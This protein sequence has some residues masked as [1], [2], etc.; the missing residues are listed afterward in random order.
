MPALLTPQEVSHSCIWWHEVTL[1][2]GPD[3]CNGRLDIWAC[4][5]LFY[6]VDLGAGLR[7]SSS[8]YTCGQHFRYHWVIDEAMGNEIEG[9]NSYPSCDPWKHEVNPA[10]HEEFGETLVPITYQ[11]GQFV[12]NTDPPYGAEGSLNDED[13]VMAMRPVGEGAKFIWEAFNGVIASGGGVTVIEDNTEIVGVDIPPVSIPQLSMA[14]NYAKIALNVEWAIWLEKD[15]GEGSLPELQRKPEYLTVPG[16]SE[17][18]A[19]YVKANLLPTTVDVLL[20]NIDTAKS[21]FENGTRFE[22]PRN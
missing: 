14:P 16:A 10:R 3:V 20:G 19:V 9:S 18:V 22:P 5:K 11:P 12:L 13:Y 1:P 17:R 7:V 2:T 21:I 6:I 4:L 8:I 15:A